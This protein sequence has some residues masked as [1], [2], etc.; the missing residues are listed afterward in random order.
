MYACSLTIL[1]PLYSSTVPPAIKE[2]VSFERNN[3]RRDYNSFKH[4]FLQ[5]S[6]ANGKLSVQNFPLLAAVENC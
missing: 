6:Y 2:N 1:S 5:Q 4:I 3:C